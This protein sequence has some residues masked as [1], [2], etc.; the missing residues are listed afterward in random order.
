[1]NLSLDSNQ[2]MLDDAVR[3]FVERGTGPGTSQVEIWSGF[4]DLGLLGLVVA[5]EHGGMG[6]GPV[7][8]YVVM[9]ALGSGLVKSPY[10]PTALVAATLIAQTGTRSQQE[11]WLSA[12]AAGS[13][14]VSI[15]SEDDDDQPG[16]QGLVLRDGRLYGRKSAAWHLGEVD[17]FIAC[18]DDG[19]LFCLDARSE[20]L[21]CT[22][23][24]NIDGY[25]SDE[26]EFAGVA[27][28]HRSELAVGDGAA[29]LEAGLDFGRAGLCA[30]ACGLLETLLQQTL[31]HLATRR[32][33]GQP[34]GSFQALQHRA[35]GMLVAVE[36]AHSAA[37]IAAAGLE[38]QGLA[39]R[40]RLVS[41]AKAQTGA[42]I[43]QVCEEAIQIFGGM[44]MTDEYAPT[45]VVRRLLAIDMSWGDR[46]FHIDRFD[47]TRA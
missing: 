13:L 7:E 11:D 18:T 27:V 10:V 33:F 26:L 42:S 8:A 46:Q 34:L 44:G 35:V 43:R 38:S 37:L 28:D 5:S 20:N 6:Y 1:M 19:L 3:R 22:R 23:Y 9:R 24:A 32:Q 15:A 30:E 41:A 40:R 16:P 2:T 39:Q 21:N 31:E 36:L 17:R 14:I 12:I 47:K 29:A 4:A 45:H 25:V